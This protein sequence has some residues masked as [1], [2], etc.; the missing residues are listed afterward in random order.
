MVAAERHKFLGIISCKEV[1]SQ[2]IIS[3]SRNWQ[4]K[5]Y[6]FD[7]NNEINIK[8]TKRVSCY[9]KSIGN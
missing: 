4:P 7:M 1:L 3:C 2:W 9:L 5:I 6:K 8:N